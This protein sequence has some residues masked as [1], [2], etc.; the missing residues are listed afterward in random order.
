MRKKRKAQIKDFL[1]EVRA[2]ADEGYSTRQLVRSLIPDIGTEL[3]IADSEVTA[4]L[5]DYQVVEL[6]IQTGPAAELFVIDVL[7]QFAVRTPMWG[8]TCRPFF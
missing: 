1:V 8:S 6:L 3:K 5:R 7:A 2:R 4:A